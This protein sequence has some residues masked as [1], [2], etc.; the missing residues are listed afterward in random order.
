LLEVL[1]CPRPRCLCGRHL[2][3][4]IGGPQ[5]F[6]CE[7]AKR[8]PVNDMTERRD[9]CELG[10]EAD[11]EPARV[12]RELECLEEKAPPDTSR[13]RST[14]GRIAPSS[15]QERVGNPEC[16]PVEEVECRPRH[17]DECGV[18]VLV[19]EQAPEDPDHL[20]R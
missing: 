3:L 6:S 20:E 14:P 11:V 10:V 7:A 9:R 4:W 12:E 18:S 17:Q 2:P 19:D 1:V 8:C 16:R 15:E 5:E 13:Q